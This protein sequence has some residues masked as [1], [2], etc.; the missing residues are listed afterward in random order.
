MQVDIQKK[1]KNK[2]QKK[3][4][5]PNQKMDRRSKYTVIQRR[6]TVGLK[7]TWKSAQN[8]YSRNENQNDNEVSPHM[9]QNGHHQKFHKQ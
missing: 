6:L 7:I 1:T 8:H 4:K 2:K 3:P 9:G 5:Q